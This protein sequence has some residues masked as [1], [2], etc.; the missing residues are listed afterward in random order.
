M[1]VIISVLIFIAVLFA[2]KFFFDM[3]D[4]EKKKDSENTELKIQ[5]A[6]LQAQLSL[7]NTGTEK[8]RTSPLCSRELS[9]AFTDTELKVAAL[10]VE[11]KEDKEIAPLVNNGISVY[12]V[13]Q[14]IRN[15]RD[16]GDFRN[17]K[18]LIAYLLRNDIV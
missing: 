3:I 16:K 13:N 11:G 15:M 1:Q 14:H 17:T 6:N 5:V 12:T 18:E 9:K 8:K 10:L 7:I 4:R 2:I